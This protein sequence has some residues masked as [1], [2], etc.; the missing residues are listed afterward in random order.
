MNYR[1]GLQEQQDAVAEAISEEAL[2]GEKLDVVW[3]LTLVAN[4]ISA[5]VAYGSIEDIKAVPGVADV[6]VERRYEPDVYSVG[7]DDPNMQVSTGMT[8]TRYCLDQRL[9]RRRNAC[10]NHRHRPGYRPPVL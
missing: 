10:G 3:N 4:A 5:N 9:H 6:V 7:G 1:A 8:G 2:G